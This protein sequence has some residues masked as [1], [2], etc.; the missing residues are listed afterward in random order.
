VAERANANQRRRILDEKARYAA[1]YI[2]K[3]GLA[4]WDGERP[5]D[6]YKLERL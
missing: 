4:I 2:G 5:H 6:R 3:S 1:M